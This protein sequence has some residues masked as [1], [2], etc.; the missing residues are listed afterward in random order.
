MVGRV[1]QTVLFS[2]INHSEKFAIFFNFF[3]LPTIAQLSAER[4]NLFAAQKGNV[5]SGRAQREE[6]STRHIWDNYRPR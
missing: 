3:D 1:G 5:G 6:D 4:D 2:S